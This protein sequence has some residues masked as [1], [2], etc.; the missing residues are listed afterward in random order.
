MCL[1]GVC[2]KNSPN[3]SESC[4]RHVMTFRLRGATTPRRTPRSWAPRSDPLLSPNR[5]THARGPSSMLEPH[6]RIWCARSRCNPLSSTRHLLTLHSAFEATICHSRRRPVA[7]R[8]RTTWPTPVV[9]PH[10]TSRPPP[11]R[12]ACPDRLTATGRWGQNSEFAGN[13]CDS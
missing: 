9:P 7:K 3:T 1:H 6:H 13:I 12:V 11:T 8:L 10:L 4:F 5:N 2:V